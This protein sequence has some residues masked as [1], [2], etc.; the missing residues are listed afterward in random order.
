MCACVREH[1]RWTDSN[2]GVKC[3]EPGVSLLKR[4]RWV[5]RPVVSWR[6]A[7]AYR[8]CAACLP[9]RTHFLFWVGVR[10]CWGFKPQELVISEEPK[11]KK[12][13][14]GSLTTNS[15]SLTEREGERHQTL[16]SFTMAV[17]RKKKKSRL[18]PQCFFPFFFFLLLIYYNIQES[19]KTVAI[20]WILPGPL[21]WPTW[22]GSGDEGRCTVG[23]AARLTTNRF[24]WPGVMFEYQTLCHTYRS[25]PFNYF[26]LQRAHHKTRAGM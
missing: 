14:S 24:R 3:G 18:N 4:S 2:N 1:C 9:A 11:R 7:A 22:T 23:G 6:S 16:C 25:S 8:V 13:L 10:E 21:S 15:D 5:C 12:K 19:H 20:S 17:S 26:L